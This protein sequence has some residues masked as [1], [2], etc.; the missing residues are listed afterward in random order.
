MVKKYKI[1]I[2][3]FGIMGKNLALNF[4]SKGFSV[5]VYDTN[6]AGMENFIRE[7]TK[8]KEIIGAKSI[9]VLTNYLEKP[10]KILLMVPA[11]KAVDSIIDKLLPNL[12]K[13]DIIIDGGNSFFQDTIKRERKLKEKD[14]Y[15]LGTG[16]SGGEEGALIGPSIMPGGDFSAWKNVKLPLQK[17]AAKAFDGS[18]CS[19]YLGKNGAGHYVKMVHNG[20]EY[21][22]M[23]LVSE[24]YC[25][26]KEILKLSNEEISKVFSSWNE[27]ELSSYLLEITEIILK[28][29]DEETGEY[30]IDL[31]LDT[32][33]QKGTGKWASQNA[34]DLGVPAYNFGTSVF[35]RFISAYKK[36]RG[37]A[38]KLLSGPKPKKLKKEKVVI[39]QFYDALY[40]SEICAYTQGFELL[41]TGSREYNWDLNLESIARIWQGGCII[42]TKLLERIKLFFAQKDKMPNLLL[43]KYFRKKFKEKQ[44]NWRKIVALAI[45]NGIPM[46]GFS[47]ALAYYDSYRSLRLPTNLIQAHRDFF[48]AHTYKRIDKEGS[49]HTKWKN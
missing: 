12:E 4:E 9:Q 1:G 45:E 36:E 18:P 5:A 44:K 25:L 3:G 31:I 38:S 39:N 26:L 47:S 22:I 8:N 27:K 17:I 16:I 6:T 42:R 32:A 28:R 35:F 23:Q 19:E 37:E 49:F 33:E 48:G 21:A 7:K 40:L 2:I 14:I 11:G 41:K 24:T 43:N 13:G 10:R 29:K 15:F 30:L 20:I 46:S 34:L